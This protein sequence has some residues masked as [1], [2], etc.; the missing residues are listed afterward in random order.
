[1]EDEEYFDAEEE[2][3][4]DNIIN[5]TNG[6][7]G[8]HL[9]DPKGFLMDDQVSNA[10][11]DTNSEA[12]AKFTNDSLI[13]IKSKLHMKKLED[14]EEKTPFQAHKMSRQSSFGSLDKIANKIDIQ[15]NMRSM[16]EDNVSEDGAAA[17]R[18]GIYGK[19]SGTDLDTDEDIKDETKIEVQKRLKL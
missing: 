1:M 12:D 13:R 17:N 3:K 5:K 6:S 4:V 19:R 16:S 7:N 15:L 9:K 18:I 14:E 8:V 2:K 11:S 10:E